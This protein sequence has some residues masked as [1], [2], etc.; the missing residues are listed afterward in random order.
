[1]RWDQVARLSKVDHV[2]VLFQGWYFSPSV[3]EHWLGILETSYDIVL[4]WDIYNPPASSDWESLL[5][6]ADVIDIYAW[7]LGGLLAMDLISEN[8]GRI[9]HL[10]TFNS[11]PCFSAKENWPGVSTDLKK[12]LKDNLDDPRKFKKQFLLPAAMGG[13][14]TKAELD[15]LSKHIYKDETD[16]EKTKRSHEY[17]LDVLF[18]LDIRETWK[19]ISCDQTHFLAD[20]DAIVPEELHEAWREMVD[21][22]G[23]QPSGLG[24]FICEWMGVL[25]QSHSSFLLNPDLYIQLMIH[26][27]NQDDDD[28]V[29]FES[30]ENF[31]DPKLI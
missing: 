3:W 15:H 16:P 24:E 26:N 12:I 14:N 21:E 30:L 18:D 27:S 17:L 31:E 25:K 23:K 4:F 7:S 19:K 2:C 9:N 5:G 11:F 6:V 20:N 1:M 8:P 10:I 22:A 13:V 28:S 29:E